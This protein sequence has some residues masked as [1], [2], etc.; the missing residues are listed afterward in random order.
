METAGVPTS[1]LLA[2]AILVAAVHAASPDHWLPLGLLARARRWPQRE[3]LGLAAAA[4]AGHVAV[5]L[6]L[7]V[8]ITAFPPLAQAVHHHE[9][10][11][12]ALLLI[13]AAA[14]VWLR[15]RRSGVPLDTALSAPHDRAR[16][17]RLRQAWDAARLAVPLG[18]AASPNIAIVPVVLIART[19]GTWTAVGVVAGFACATLIAFMVL[20]LAAQWTTDR[21]PLAWMERHADDVA[22]GLL[23]ALGVAAWWGL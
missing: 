21:L 15:P 14:V 7:G 9:G 23:A 8:G 19:R 20:A 5:S 12:I 22:A 6:L 16:P 18:M 11:A 3:T 2:T 17:Q 13:I 4:G 1:V 10:P